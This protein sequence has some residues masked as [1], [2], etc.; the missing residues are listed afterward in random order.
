MNKK[1][2]IL[3][4]ICNKQI[5]VCC[6]K[7]HKISCLRKKNKNYFSIPKEW[8]IENSNDY[9]CIICQKV[10]SLKGMI[11]HYWRKHTQQGIS[12]IQKQKPWENVK[13]KLLGTSWNKG[14]SKNN[15]LSL[16]KQSKSLKNRYKD[17]SGTFTGKSHTYNTRRKMRMSALKRIEEQLEDGQSIYPRVGI[18]EK[19]CITELQKLISYNILKNRRIDGFFPDGFISELKMVIEF[20]E[21]WH[22]TSDWAIEHDKLKCSSYNILKLNLFTVKEIDWVNNKEKV[23]NEFKNFI[24]N[25]KRKL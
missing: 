14:L 2:T 12:F 6:I 23:L 3:C 16:Q 25:L 20:N 1:P 10:F 5:S 7:L 9:K 8:K 13:R 19:I 18:L 24:F 17:K 21:N 15:N 11:S 4:E 22:Y